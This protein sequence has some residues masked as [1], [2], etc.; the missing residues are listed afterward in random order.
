MWF[1]GPHINSDHAGR[2]IGQAMPQAYQ[3][4]QTPIATA[5][6]HLPRVLL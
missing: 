1:G 5:P 4:R 2:E 3:E 6:P